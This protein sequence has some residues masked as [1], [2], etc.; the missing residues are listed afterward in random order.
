VAQLTVQPIPEQ[1]IIDLR[2]ARDARAVQ[3]SVRLDPNDNPFVRMS[4]LQRKRLMVRVLC[5][6]VAYDPPMPVAFRAPPPPPS[7]TA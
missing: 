4:P 2:A 1:A 3:E 5:E 7:L 6:L